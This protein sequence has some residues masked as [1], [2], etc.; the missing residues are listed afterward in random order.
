[1]VHLRILTYLKVSM[2]DTRDLRVEISRVALFFTL[3]M[4]LKGAW[5]IFNVLKEKPGGQQLEIRAPARISSC[6]VSPHEGAHV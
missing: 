5:Y 1:V 4:H 3:I 6:C 2:C